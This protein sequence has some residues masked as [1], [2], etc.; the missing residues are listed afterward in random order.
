MEDENISRGIK[1]VAS[2]FG[3][4]YFSLQECK[5]SSE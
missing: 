2:K 1:F 5:W 4:K 3:E